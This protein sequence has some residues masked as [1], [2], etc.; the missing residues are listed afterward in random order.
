MVVYSVREVDSFGQVLADR[1]ITGENCQSVLRDLRSVTQGT[2][3]IEVYN[4]EG[5][6]AGA[7][8]VEYWRQRL[9][10]R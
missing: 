6:K 10:R 7:I 3:R 5:E 9:R 4:A 8:G 1:Q 2:E